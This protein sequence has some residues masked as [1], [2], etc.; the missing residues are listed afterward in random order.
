MINISCGAEMSR[1]I[2]QISFNPLRGFSDLFN[3]IFKSHY[4]SEIMEKIFLNRFV[5]KFS[6]KKLS[7][8]TLICFMTLMFPLIGKS[9]PLTKVGVFYFP[10]WKDNQA[11]L[12]YEKPW[13]PI[14]KFPEREPFIGW[15]KEGEDNVMDLQITWMHDHGIGFVV[16]D[17]YWGGHRQILGHA[18]KSY[19]NINRAQKIPYALMWANHGTG[20][21]NYIDFIEMTDEL[22]LNHFG[23]S[24]YLKV[25]GRPLF[26]VQIPEK[27]EEKAD[28]FNSSTIE[29][30]KEM[31]RRIK[32]AGIPA[33]FIVGGAAA[34]SKFAIHGGGKWGY[35]AYFMYNYHS[36]PGGKIGSEN[37]SSYS[38]TELDAAYRQHWEWFIEKGD[39]PY[40]LPMTAGWDRRPWGGSKDPAHDL[41]TPTN[42]E[43]FDHI[44]FGKKVIDKYNQKTLGLGIICC[45]NEYGEGSIIEPTKHL[46]FKRLETI[47]D[48]FGRQ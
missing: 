20:P 37:R 31:Q 16:F 44:N 15:Y 5:I 2:R 14:K 4:S 46:G 6:Y 35:D 11:G 29:L 24:D 7:A 45:W 21:Q 10:G 33:A 18:L 1:A 38:Y 47:R 8:A 19:H 42:F 25:D 43:F 12:L 48:V 23:R 28:N 9:N 13:D 32:L 30:I 40:I 27:L 17:W 39:L 41:S 34:G 22:I 36:G 26:F 3:F